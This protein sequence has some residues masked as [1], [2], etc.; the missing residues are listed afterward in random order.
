MDLPLAIGGAA[1]AALAVGGFYYAALWPESQIFGQSLIAGRDSSEVALTFD[2][3][4]NEP[5]TLHLLEVLARHQVHATFFLIGK[6]VRAHPEIARAVHSAGHTIG[7]HTMN[8]PRLMYLPKQELY[9]E[10]SGAHALLEDV[11]GE[12]VHFFRPPFGARRP[13][14]MRAVRELGIVSVLWNVSSHDWSA[15]SAL[16][17]ERRVGRGMVRNQER[18]RGSNVLLH[19]GSHIDFGTDRRRTVAATAALLTS[20]PLAGVR[21]ATLD[22]WRP[23]PGSKRS[24]DFRG[25]FGMA[26]SD[27]SDSR[28]HNASDS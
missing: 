3:G 9:E 21:A 16:E 17:I 14:V 20:F 26:E 15:G 23:L 25:P 22:E 11:L 18:Q 2:D 27:S 5:Y 24:S 13:A 10:I 28:D 6:Y 1:A 4:P 19:D 8:H 7:S 12:K